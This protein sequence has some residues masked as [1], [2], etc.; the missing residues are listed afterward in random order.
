MMIFSRKM[1]VVVDCVAVMIAG[2]RS[3]SFKNCTFERLGA[4]GLRLYLLRTIYNIY[5]IM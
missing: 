2:A 3:V 1:A 4:W 5:I